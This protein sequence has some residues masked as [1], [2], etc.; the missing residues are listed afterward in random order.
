LIIESGLAGRR[1]FGGAR[2]QVRKLVRE[3][4]LETA[5]MADHPLIR[6]GPTP[7]SLEELA[8]RS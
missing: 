6:W 4:G 1:R 7:E 8:K 2:E 5:R 3:C